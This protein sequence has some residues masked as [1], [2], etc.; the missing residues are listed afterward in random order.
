MTGRYV[1][2]SYFHDGFAMIKRSIFSNKYLPYLLILP[3][4][5][6]TL[7]FFLLASIERADQ[8]HAS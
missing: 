8:F 3:Q 7:T 2:F 5:L 6:V 4:I 1:F